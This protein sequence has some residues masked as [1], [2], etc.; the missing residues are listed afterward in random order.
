MCHLCA[1]LQMHQQPSVP[2]HQRGLSSLAYVTHPASVIERDANPAPLQS[3]AVGWGGTGRDIERDMRK[4][5]GYRRQRSACKLWSSREIQTQRWP[6]KSQ[7]GAFL[8]DIRHTSASWASAELL[9]VLH[10]PI[11]ASPWRTKASL[12]ALRR[13]N[14]VGA[15]HLLLPPLSCRLHPPWRSRAS[16][17]WS[18][19]KM[20]KTSAWMQLRGK[21]LLS[22]VCVCRGTNSY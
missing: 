20:K 15:A 22:F 12:R 13:G 3:L 11:Q 9:R 6:W 19:A 10:H 4:E 2:T 8:T 14:A 7:T 16:P 1:S 18:C 17:L 5:V 21:R